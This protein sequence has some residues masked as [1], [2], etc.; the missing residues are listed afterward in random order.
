MSRKNVFNK[1]LAFVLVLLIGCK[2]PAV[3]FA[4]GADLPSGGVV[5]DDIQGA[6]G[7]LN[8]AKNFHIFSNEAEL[9]VHTNGNIA[10]GRLI[11]NVNFGTGIYEGLISKEIHYL[12][13]IVSIQRSSF[14]ASTP[15]R[16]LKVVFGSGVDISFV[17][18]G[19]KIAVN[20]T[21]LDNLKKTGEAFI[22][23]NG[24]KYMAS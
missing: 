23:K 18:H 3:S 21:Q 6:T 9:N 13:S 2:L 14:V 20:G 24:K 8:V 1:L 10:T 19:N 15:T 16:G 22:D 11:G 12:Q 5:S 17:E 4:A 7:G